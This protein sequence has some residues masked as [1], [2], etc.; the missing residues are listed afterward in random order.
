MCNV[1]LR[2]WAVLI[3]GPPSRC[4]GTFSYAD[5]SSQLPQ[6]FLN[7]ARLALGY[8]SSHGMWRLEHVT[9]EP[10]ILWT[11]ASLTGGP[12][13]SERDGVGRTLREKIKP[14]G[15]GGKGARGDKDLILPHL[16]PQRTLAPDS[17]Q[18]VDQNHLQYTLVP[19]CPLLSPSAQPLGRNCESTVVTFNGIPT[20]ILGPWV[21]FLGG[22][23]LR[24]TVQVN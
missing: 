4:H 22:S 5:E 21:M 12:H 10:L 13:Q 3:P 17:W 18:S 16:C 11:A 23:S 2:L 7:T 14:T 1:G 20:Q 8:L 19:C 6:Y 24:G 9:R 15:R